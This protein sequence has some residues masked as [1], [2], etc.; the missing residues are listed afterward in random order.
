[1]NA[2]IQQSATPPPPL[3][4]AAATASPTLTPTATPLAW[5]AE[6]EAT[7]VHLMTTGNLTRPQAV[8]EFQKLKKAG[9]LPAIA[10]TPAAL[11]TQERT[12]RY[13]FFPR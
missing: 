9:K 2:E 12:V 3:S 4:G 5:T 1:M 8:R 11:G 10:L 7:I 13:S 6:E